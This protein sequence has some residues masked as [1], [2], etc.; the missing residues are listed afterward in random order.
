MLMIKN[1]NLAVYNYNS[2]L[3]YLI[4]HFKRSVSIQGKIKQ[5]NQI[6]LDSLKKYDIKYF[7]FHIDLTVTDDFFINK[8]E[9]IEVLHLKNIRTI[10]SNLSDIRKTTIQEACKKIKI[11][12]VVDNINEN[13][14]IIIKSNFNNGAAK[15]LNLS[16]NEKTILKLNYLQESSLSYKIFKKIYIKVIDNNQYIV[17]KFIENK[18]DLFYRAYKLYNR[19]VVS[20]VVDKNKIKKMPIGISRQNYFFDL[21]NLDDH[22]F[23]SIAY[24]I[25]KLSDYMNIDYAAFDIVMSDDNEFYI[26]DIN[27]TPFWGSVASDKDYEIINYLKSALDE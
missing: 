6:I 23:Y 15:E 27:T 24:Q 7:L 10:N 12:N 1:Y 16:K 17:E 26:I 18:Q 8:K 14:I 25:K 21:F 2:Y 22:K 11:N 20:E 9:L 4:N 3:N 5:K 13:D 19:L